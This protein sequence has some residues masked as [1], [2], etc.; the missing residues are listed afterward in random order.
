MDNSSFGMPHALTPMFHL[1][2][3]AS[4]ESSAYT[5]LLQRLSVAVQHGNADAACVMGSLGSEQ[6][7]DFFV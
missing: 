7:E 1:M 4:G 6:M 2:Q 5:F 3:L